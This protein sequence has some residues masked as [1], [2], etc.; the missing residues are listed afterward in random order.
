MGLNFYRHRACVLACKVVKYRELMAKARDVI[1][2]LRARLKFS[3][4]AERLALA[5]AKRSAG[6]MRRMA[7]DWDAMRAERDAAR[8]EAKALR[9]ELQ[10]WKKAARGFE[11]AA[12]R[13]A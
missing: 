12:K 2:D 10:A 3:Q 7:A 11:L 13:A 5:K 6:S 1:R 4:Q 9:R 8:A